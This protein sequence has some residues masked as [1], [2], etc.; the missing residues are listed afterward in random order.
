M[1]DLVGNDFT[2][3]LITGSVKTTY[4]LAD[5]LENEITP[6]SGAFTLHNGNSDMF[7]RFVRSAFFG[8]A[9]QT[10]RFDMQKRGR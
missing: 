7:D 1:C 3:L 2:G 6:L 9:E 4:W 8:W 10:Y 5:S